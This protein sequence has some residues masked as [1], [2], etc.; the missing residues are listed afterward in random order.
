MSQRGSAVP[1]HSPAEALELRANL[2]L[3]GRMSLNEQ[4]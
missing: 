1:S 3:S 4:A 2:P